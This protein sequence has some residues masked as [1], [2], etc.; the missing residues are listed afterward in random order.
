MWFTIRIVFD[1]VL[2]VIWCC[3][4]IERDFE[5]GIDL[6]K[7]RKE[8]GTYFTKPEKLLNENL[9]LQIIWFTLKNKI[10]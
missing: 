9:F 7:G 5:V 1:F 10:E 8:A 2:N 4:W 3:E 6:I